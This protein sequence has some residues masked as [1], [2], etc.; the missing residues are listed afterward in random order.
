[1]SIGPQPVFSGNLTQSGQQRCGRR[2]LK[3]ESLF[4]LEFRQ[5]LGLLLRRHISTSS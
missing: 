2:R 1:M 4:L 5:R 3:N